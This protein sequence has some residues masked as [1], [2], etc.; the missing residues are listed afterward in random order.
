[1]LIFMFIDKWCSNY[2]INV[3]GLNIYC[4]EYTMIY[5]FI[6]LYWI[7]QDDLNKRLSRLLQL[8]F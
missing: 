3:F 7:Y 1:M 8:K 6:Y 5:K 2:C 4:L